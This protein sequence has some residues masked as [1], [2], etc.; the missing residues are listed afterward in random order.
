LADFHAVPFNRDN[1]LDQVD[2][3]LQRQDK[4]NLINIGQLLNSLDLSVSLVEIPRAQLSRVPCPAVFCKEGHITLIE[5]IDPTGELRLLDP[6]LGPLRVEAKALQPD[7]DGDGDGDRLSILLLRRRP[8][9]KEQRFSWAWY[10]P[11]LKPHRRE[12]VEV[13]VTS[14]V[15][16]VLALV[17]PLGIMRLVNARTGGDNSLDAVVSIG[18]ILIAASVVTAIASALRS[19]IF[20][21][22]ANRVDMDT[23]ETILDRLVRLPQ[24]FFDARPVGRITYYFNMLDRLRDFLIG[25]A[26]TTLVDFSFSLL[27][28]AVLF[29]LNR[30]EPHR[31]DGGGRRQNQQLSH[32][33]DHGDPNDQIPKR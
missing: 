27:Y 32:R 33:S 12:L 31:P 14:G 28:V 30:G 15:V 22:V 20:T 16:N 13:L 25:Q 3:L 8:D 23:R 1:L 26:L 4:L 2:A 17:T 19:L 24:G 21:G 29:S 18:V 6:E 11:F 10:G 9:S 5:G 7:G